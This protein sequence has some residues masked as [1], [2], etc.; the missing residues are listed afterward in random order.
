MAQ[1]PDPPPSKPTPPPA[2]TRKDDPRFALLMHPDVRKVIRAKLRDLHIPEHELD[3]LEAD[4][5]DEACLWAMKLVEQGKDA[6]DSEVRWKGAVRDIAKNV[7]IDWIK[8]HKNQTEALAKPCANA[9]VI[10]AAPESSEHPRDVKKALGV[11]NEMERNEHADDLMDARQAGDGVSEAGRE[12]GIGAG[13][14]HNI[15]EKTREKFVRRMKLAGLAALLPAG[16]GMWLLF[17][18]TAPVDLPVPA[19]TS[20][21]TEA[22]QR[23]R[24]EG[25]EDD[26]DSLRQKAAELR[27][28]ANAECAAKQWEACRDDIAA[29]N[30]I[31][32]DYRPERELRNAK[33]GH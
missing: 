7:A 27:Q 25:G 13:R 22:P 10:G 14:A 8:R 9:E 18:V 3:Q 2:R 11:W 5:I 6:P 23:Q 30:R 20:A 15:E 32:P 4:V 1:P 16:L 19:H 33:P 29:A 17:Y 26:P 12:L 21:R 28:K 31:D 24:L